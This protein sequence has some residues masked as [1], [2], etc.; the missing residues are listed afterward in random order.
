LLNVGSGEYVINVVA[1]RSVS[2]GLAS[3]RGCCLRA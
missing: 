1:C 2:V 3:S